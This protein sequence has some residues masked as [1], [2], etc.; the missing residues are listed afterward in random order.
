MQTTTKPLVSVCIPAYNRKE[1]LRN[2]LYSVTR[3]TLKN[4]EII[5][6]DNCS[7]E[8]LAEVIREFADS[9]ICYHRNSKNLG[10]ARNFIRAASLAEGKYLKFLCSD[11]LLLPNCL[12]D[13]VKELES[14]PEA[15]A[16]L[17]KVASFNES[18]CKDIG[19]Y[20]MPW[21]G[22]ARDLKLS[23]HPQVFEFLKVSPT[24]ILFR[25]SAF[26]ELGGFDQCLRA[27][28]DWEIYARMLQSEGGVVFLDRVLAIYRLH[29]NNDA[30]VQSS[31]FG[32]MHDMLN[33]RRQERL[34]RRPIANADAIWRQCSQSIRDGKGVLPVLKVIF[35]YGFL[36]NFLFMLPVLIVKHLMDRVKRNLKPDNLLS[37]SFVGAESE[38]ERLL[39]ETWTVSNSDGHAE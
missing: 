32:F 18:G 23:E 7:E 9:R 37:C 33:L 22:H 38:L 19:N 5:V 28:L 35:D 13:S 14:Y 25:S 12:E 24:A 3:Q 6:S 11:D 31:N 15:D 16:L 20:G 30:R 17:F 2:C 1:M 4:I 29:D 39:N 27:M 8:D 36:G 26:W 21:K 10:P 34:P